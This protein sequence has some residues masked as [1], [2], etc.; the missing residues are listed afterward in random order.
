MQINNDRNKD[1]AYILNII[2]ILLFGM[3][4]D[5]SFIYL[6]GS[7]EL[8]IDNLEILFMNIS[9]FGNK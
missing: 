4:I 9:S 8:T 7:L 6:P 5:I 2:L 1:D 3:L